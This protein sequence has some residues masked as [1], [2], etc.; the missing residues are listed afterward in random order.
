MQQLVLGA[1]PTG[2]RRPILLAGFGGW[3]DAGSAATI[4]LRHVLGDTSPPASAM[5]DPSACYDFTVARPL[6]TRAQDGRGWSL[7]YPKV[8]FYPIALPDAQRDALV[9]LGPEPHFRW[10]ELAPAIVTYARQAGVQSML[11]LGAYVG[12][13]THRSA[14]VVR[15]TLDPGLAQRLE[16]LELEDTDYEGPTAFAT[17]LLHAAAAGGVTAA[18]LWVATPPYLQAGN[19]VAALALLEA[20]GRVTQLPLEVTKLREVADSFLHDVDTALEE[21]PE[22]AEQLNQML[23]A[24]QEDADDETTLDAEPRARWRGSDPDRPPPD[25]PPGLPS[26][27]GL[28]EAVEKYLRQARGD[29]PPPTTGPAV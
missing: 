1:P 7:E 27:K 28:V 25:A 21:H 19:P 16:D 8:A 26:G 5:L 20:A 23:E 10:P 11:T 14:P 29:E 18:S 17:A 12:P 15:R 22:L 4:A 13:V 24:E 6:S 9:L 2:L 3:G